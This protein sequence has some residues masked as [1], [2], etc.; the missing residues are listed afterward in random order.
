MK[1]QYI[2]VNNT[3]RPSRVFQLEGEPELVHII[4][5]GYKDTYAVFYEDA[6][7]LEPWQSGLKVFT[8]E[9]IK[10]KFNI[11]L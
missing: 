3:Y 5:L 11:E 10:Q 2:E 9:E 7:E 8:A 4:K 1:Q 6:Y